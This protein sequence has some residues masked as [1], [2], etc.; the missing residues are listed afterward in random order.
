MASR[1]AG[2]QLGPS[3]L[4]FRG[5]VPLTIAAKVAQ[6]KV[7]ERGFWVNEEPVSDGEIRGLSPGVQYL[8]GDEI[9]L[10]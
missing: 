3:E 2:P 9:R 5:S 10:S 1:S 6:L 7:D 8:T 4:T